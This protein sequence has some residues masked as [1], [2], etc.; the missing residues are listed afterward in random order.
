MMTLLIIAVVFVLAGLVKGVS[1]MGLPTVA[2]ALLSLFI[3][4][5]QSAM[6]MVAPTLATNLAQCWG[7]HT[8]LLVRKL[9]WLWCCLAFATILSPL[10]DIADEGSNALVFLGVVLMAYSAWGLTK[11]SLPSQRNPH[12]VIGAVIG[13]ITGMVTAATGVFALPMVP[14]IQM[15]GL[16]KEQ[17]IQGLGISF[18]VATIALATRLGAEIWLTPSMSLPVI[19]I[20]V[21]AAFIGMW[22]GARVRD[23]LNPI[24]FQKALYAVLGSLGLIMLLRAI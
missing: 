13:G 20:A 24:Q 12:P 22:S 7:P 23:R 14:Y 9:G 21:G 19:S 4:P 16:T 10:P 17:Y 2:I 5:A 8:A 6:L 15:L 1:G 11:P 18:M 3:P